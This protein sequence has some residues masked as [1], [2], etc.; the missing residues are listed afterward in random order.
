MK[1]SHLQAM[2]VP[3]GAGGVPADSGAA[4]FDVGTPEDDSVDRWASCTE[5]VSSS[6]SSSA[7]QDLAAFLTEEP[8]AARAAESPSRP[9]PKGT[10]SLSVSSSGGTGGNF[11]GTGGNLPH[12]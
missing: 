6:S 8:S 5:C 2:L 3:D 1:G 12:G 7:F 11:V 10:S 9:C 4:G